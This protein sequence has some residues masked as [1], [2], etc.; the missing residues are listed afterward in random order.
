MAYLP[1][2]LCFFFS[3]VLLTASGVMAIIRAGF[4]I[5]ILPT[6]GPGELP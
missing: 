5:A 3:V 2:L 6:A 1:Q 4:G